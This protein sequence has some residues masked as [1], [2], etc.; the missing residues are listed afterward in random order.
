MC[1]CCVL[2]HLSHVRLFVTL[3]TL[4]HQAPLSTGFSR[5]EY[6]STYMEWVAVPSFR[7]SS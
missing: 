7:G 1:V 2:S 3:W 5:Q 4:A 6:F